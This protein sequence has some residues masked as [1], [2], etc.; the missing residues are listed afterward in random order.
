MAGGHRYGVDHGVTFHVEPK[1]RTVLWG[2][3]GEPLT[4]EEV[5]GGAQACATA[6]AGDAGRAARR[7]T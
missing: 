4:D 5:A 7:R 6:L 3:Q 2:W 1:L